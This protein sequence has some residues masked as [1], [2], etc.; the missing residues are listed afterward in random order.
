[1]VSSM[2][3]AGTIFLTRLITMLMS[4]RFGAGSMSP[5]WLVMMCLTGVLVRTCCSVLAKFSRMTMAFAPESFNWCSSSRGVYS[6]L[7]LTTVMPARR[8]PNN[9]TGYCS[10]F[11]DMMATRSPRS[12]PGRPCRNAAK[13]RDS[14]STSA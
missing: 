12:M 11:G 6:G 3:H 14:R 7:T 5:S 2:L 10:R 13:S 4:R 8:I 9:A 1:M